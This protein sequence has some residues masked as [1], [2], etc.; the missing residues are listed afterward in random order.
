MSS[1]ERIQ[2]YIR[3][4]PREKPAV[5]LGKRPSADWPD[6]GTIEFKEVNVSSDV[7]AQTQ[8]CSP[9]KKSLAVF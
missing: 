8:G 7:H 9:L 2:T 6:H 1:A 5:I 3:E 4:V